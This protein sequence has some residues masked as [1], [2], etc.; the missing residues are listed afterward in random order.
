MYIYI[1]L[2]DIQFY[3]PLELKM[4]PTFSS[5]YHFVQE[6]RAQAGNQRTQ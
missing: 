6:K 1:Y 3:E 4:I 2:Y 5:P